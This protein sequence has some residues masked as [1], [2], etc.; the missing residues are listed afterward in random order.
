MFCKKCG[1]EIKEEWSVCPNCGEKISENQPKNSINEKGKQK[2]KKPIGKIIIIVIVIIVIWSVLNSEDNSSK[3][4][5]GYNAT[6]QEVIL[7]DAF[8]ESSEE[9]TDSNNESADI[10]KY[11]D[12]RN[13]EDETPVHVSNVSLTQGIYSGMI[14]IGWDITNN[15]EKDLKTIT[16][17]LLAWDQNKLPIEMH[18]TTGE[19]TY[20]IKMDGMNLAEGE[21]QSVNGD[22]FY[23]SATMKYVEIVVINYE[24]FDGN[25]WESPALDYLEKIAG[26]KYDDSIMPAFEFSD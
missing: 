7:S 18:T 16:F 9:E 11:L 26:Q 12:M 22:I 13:D 20:L 14:N 10:I 25:T 15:E 3:D 23:N 4:E 1:K 21:T 8:K 17:A 24:D 6:N 5:E 19:D 2:K